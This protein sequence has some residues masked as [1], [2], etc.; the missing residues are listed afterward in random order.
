MMN[1]KLAPKQETKTALLR[2]GMEIMLEKGY[3]N[4]GIQE[5]LSSLGVPKGS[6]YHYFESKESFAV[7]I[8]HQFDHDYLEELIQILD[9]RRQTPLQR[10]KTYCEQGKAN[11]ESQACRKGCLIGNLSQEMSD[12]S[13]VL[14]KE[15]STVMARWRDLFAA[16][17]AEGQLSR[18]I[19]TVASAYEIA[20][21]FS[22][23]WS[24]AVMRAKTVKN[25]EPMDIFI[26]LMFKHFLQP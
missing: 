10:L 6:F 11:F 13:E 22:S 12:Q 1:T 24:G 15:L 25:V 8:I 23:G 21:F 9:D 17:I 16:C 20:E 3:T 19:T 26:E 14:R 5:V 4:T 18:E 2:T 7:A